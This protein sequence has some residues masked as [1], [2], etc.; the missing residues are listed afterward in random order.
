VPA[1]P[2]STIS[3]HLGFDKF[4]V[5]PTTSDMQKWMNSSPYYDVGIYLPGSKN[6]SNDPNLTPAWLSDVQGQNQAW[7]YYAVMVRTPVGLR[8]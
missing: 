4:P 1:T 6:K 5:I 3:A 8:L 2:S 7:G